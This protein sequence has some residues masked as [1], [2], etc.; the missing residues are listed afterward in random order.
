VARQVGLPAGV[1]LAATGA[2]IERARAVE[3]GEGAPHVG[4]SA[5]A[6]TCPV[7]LHVGGIVAGSQL[8]R[9]KP[10]FPDDP[11]PFPG[12][13]LAVAAGGEDPHETVDGRQ[14]GCDPL[15]V[16]LS[17]CIEAGYPEAAISVGFGRGGCIRSPKSE[18]G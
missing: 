13:Q 7:P 17:D 1:S 8:R 14:L 10:A 5:G 3:R 11:E 16:I 4:W 6:L 2:A 18:K 15:G 9:S 12:R